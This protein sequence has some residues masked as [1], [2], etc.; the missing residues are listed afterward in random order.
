MQSVVIENI[1]WEGPRGGAIF[2]ATA[3]DGKKHRI[4]ANAQVMPR[5][6]RT[7][8]IWDINGVIR[9]DASHGP[10]VIADK[11]ILCK[12]SGRLIIRTI[13]GSN[14]FPDIGKKGAKDLW[15]HLG[16]SLYGYLAEGKPEPFVEILGP[17]LSQVLVNGW[18]ELDMEAETYRWLDNHGLPVG[19]AKTLLRTYRK[20]V[21]DLLVENPYRLVSFVSWK[22]TDLVGRCLGVSADDPRRLVGAVDALVY[23]RLN[24]SH[25]VTPFDTFVT[26]LRKL[27][28]CT[29]NIAVEATKLGLQAKA[30]ELVGEVQGLGCF[31]ME[32]FISS[33]VAEMV[34]GSF[35]Q[36]E[37][38]TIRQTPTVDQLEGIFAKFTKRTGLVLN[39]Q[40]RESV[41]VGVTSPIACIVG[42]AGVGKTTVLNAVHLSTDVLGF[43]GVYQ[44]AL[45][46]RAA[47]RMEEA[48]N[49]KAYTIA[50]FLQAFDSG[51]LDLTRGPLLIID[52][53]SMLDLSLC[54]RIMRRM[55]PGARL[56][57]VGDAAQLPPIGFGLTFHALVDYP[58]IPTVE[59]T[60][61]HR[62]AAATGIP[63]ISVDIRNGIVPKLN[64]YTGRGQG[65]SFIDTPRDQILD[66]LL[67]VVHDL[68]I[69]GGCQVIGAV[70]R[71]AAGVRTINQ[72]FHSL[73]AVGRPTL[74][75]FAEGEPVIWTVNDYQLGLLNG[76]LGVVIS[77]ENGLLVEFDGVQHAISYPE[78]KNLEHAYAIT[79]HKS[80]GSQFE[81]VV[82]PIF[83]SRILDRT[84][85]YTAITRAKE[86]VVLIG[87]RSAFEKAII[88]PPASSRRETGIATHLR[89]GTTPEAHLTI[90]PQ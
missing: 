76:S 83:Q 41:L 38:H 40:Q 70:K 79:V 29:L 8:E 53:A 84:L 24:H 57:L 89:G 26:R 60:E 55:P 45:S 51:K 73:L 31:S 6:P 54:Y 10:Q 75:G 11:A 78:V 48:T 5:S 71:W 61:I 19:L 59:L 67:D 14:L 3:A 25:T 85:L 22:Q 32:R 47:K 50:G 27:L 87:D 7:G 28:G 86:Q 64:N 42:G 72:E 34:S 44:M 33:R 9:L 15:E 62:Q 12:P 17:A 13:S 46:G 81:R 2:N 66:S 1:L 20:D 49:R 88:E 56:L 58:Q 80:Q 39:K 36:P 43:G 68:G 65:V 74:H 77:V 37:N 23:L 21:V 63:Q 16:E 4:V 52:E 35:D 69:A 82:I 30:I 18:K 90:L